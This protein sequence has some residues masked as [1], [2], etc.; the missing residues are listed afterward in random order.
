MRLI[1][2]ITILLLVPC[3]AAGQSHLLNKGERGVF[4]QGNYSWTIGMAAKSLAIGYTADGQADA[5]LSFSET[6]IK[7][8][9]SSQP[10]IWTTSQFCNIQLFRFSSIDRNSVT[11]SLYEQFSFQGGSLIP[12][13]R[14]SKA[15]ALGGVTSA[16]LRTQSKAA[17]LLSTGYYRLMALEGGGEAQ[18][19]YSVGAGVAIYGRESVWSL[20]FDVGIGSEITT[21]GFTLSVG[22][23]GRIR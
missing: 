10:S 12:K 20:A 19:V 13:A 2:I 1:G 18:D 17:I 7:G 3:L 21:Y 6:V 23:I 8:R 4:A 14:A 5:G 11:L 16:I 22:H 15:L 9:S